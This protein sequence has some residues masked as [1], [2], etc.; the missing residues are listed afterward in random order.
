MAFIS[1][2]EDFIQT[3]FFEHFESGFSLIVKDNYRK[4]NQEKRGTVKPKNKAKE[5][6]S[7]N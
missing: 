7:N 3:I 5:I 2:L 4:S 6:K 1:D